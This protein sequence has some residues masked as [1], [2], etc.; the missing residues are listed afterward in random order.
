MLRHSRLSETGSNRVQDYKCFF[1]NVFEIKIIKLKCFSCTHPDLH[2]LLP[3]GTAMNSV[4]GR[5][6]NNTDTDTHTQTHTHTH[7]LHSFSL[8]TGV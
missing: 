4:V 7:S 6:A 1:L 5:F 2:Q 3:G 8:Y